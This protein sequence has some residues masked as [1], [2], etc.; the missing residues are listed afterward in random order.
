MGPTIGYKNFLVVEITLCKE[1]EKGTRLIC[2]VVHLRKNSGQKG[3]FAIWF[4]DCWDSYWQVD[5]LTAWRRGLTP[6]SA[7]VRVQVSSS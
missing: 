2:R 4:F 6:S 5:Y 1:F 3:V 7:K